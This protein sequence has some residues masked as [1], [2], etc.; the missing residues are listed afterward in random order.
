M[1]NIKK[2][3]SLKNKLIVYFT[4]IAVIPALAISL[5]YYYD[6]KKMLNA[7]MVQNATSDLTYIMS[8]IDKQLKLAEQLSDWIFINTTDITVNSNYDKLFLK[9][10]DKQDQEFVNHSMNFYNAVHSTILGTSLEKYIS[11]LLIIGDNGV[12]IRDGLDAALVDKDEIVQYDWF[13]RQ[14]MNGWKVN[15]QPIVENPA[16]VKTDPYIF[17][18]IR[19]IINTRN[20]QQIGWSF[21]AFKSSLISDLF[22]NYAVN[23]EDV[24]FL[25]DPQGTLIFHSDG[26]RIGKSIHQE[27][28]FKDI[29]HKGSGYITASINGKEKNLVF[30][31]SNVNDWV[32]IQEVSNAFLAKQKT[33]LVY[34]SILLFFCSI[35]LSSVLS[36]FLSY[37]LTSPLRRILKK[38]KRIA[39]G[40]F[41]KEPGIEGDDELGM[42]GKGINHMTENINGLMKQLLEE[43]SKKRHLELRMLQ[44]QIN[45]HFLYNTLNSIRWIAIIQKADGVRDAITSLGRLLKNTLGDTSQEI[46]LKEELA[47]LNDYVLIQKLRYMESVEVKYQVENEDLLNCKILKMTLQP[48]VENAIFHGI[49]PKKDSGLITI[50]VVGKP[51]AL[52]ICI[53]DD[54]IGM[55]EEQIEI[56]LREDKQ[57]DTKRGFSAIGIRNVN[58]RIKL[59]YGEQYGIHIESKVGEYT[60]VFVRI[61]GLYMNSV[62]ERGTVNV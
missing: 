7:S 42:L 58:E 11:S 54:G 20:N 32:I 15:W 35:C 6:E 13:K 38:M 21:I 27:P 29:L 30:C 45:P 8:N 10:W 33:T 2:P 39:S 61:P 40:D 36:V 59:V 18:F 23:R 46:T 1:I 12:D 17:P 47:L 25:I 51:E 57:E 55:T 4:L 60:R 53:E 9:E 19:P 49:E 22:E 31:K 3:K 43:E 14:M 44:S 56:L 48:L 41:S 37:N 50:H 26:K 28:Y 52:E 5:Y 62:E 34:I 16:S 24:I